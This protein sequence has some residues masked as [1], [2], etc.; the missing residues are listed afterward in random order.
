[1][2]VKVSDWK[3]ETAPLKSVMPKLIFRL[4][5]RTR[6]GQSLLLTGN[7]PLLGE[8]RIENAIPLHYL[9]QDCWE[10][11]VAWKEGA[12]DA[13]IAYEYL[14]RNADGS[15]VRDWGR[16]R[17]IN[18]ARL[19]H[20]EVLVVDSWNEPGWYENAFCTQ[21]FQRVLLKGPADAR[22]A[23]VP[24]AT[25]TFNVKAPLL[26][27]DQTLCL[28]GDAAVLGNWDTTKPPVLLGRVA[29]DGALTVQLYLRGQSFPIAYR[30]AVYDLLKKA[31]VRYEGGEN[32]VLDDVA[33][34]GKHTIVND[35]FAVLPANTWKGAGVAIPVFSLRSEGSF[36]VGEFTDLELLAD[37]GK[38]AGLKLIQLLPINDTTATHTWADSYPYSAISAFALHPLYLNLSHV[39][40]GANR[41]LLE[42]LE[43]EQKRLNAL[44]ALDYEAVIQAKFNFIRR[45]YPS[46]CEK[47]FRS[48]G[49]R[50][51]FKRNRHWLEPYAAFCH[52]RDKHG[53]ADF[54]QWPTHRRYEAE[55]IANL[56]A[57]NSPAY[58]EIAL[59]YF[60][61]YQL[62]L[63]L[64]AAIE[65]AH[66]AGIVVKGDLP[67]GVCR[68]GADTWKDPELYHMEYQAGAPPDPFSAK[69][70]NWSFPTYNWARM[71]AD[72]Y[73]WWW[74]RLEQMN[75]YFD[76]FRIDHILGFFRI[77][78]IPWE[79]VEGLLGHF[80]PAIPV[81]SKEF[82]ARGI[83]IDHDRCAR[84]YI[85]NQILL[86]LFPNDQG[87]VISE[88]LNPG[89]AGNYSLKPEFATQR[90]VEKHFAARDRNERNEK[91]KQGLFDLISNVILF[92]VKGSEGR[93][94]HF[95]FFM[96]H[97]S[98]FK[99]LPA[100]TREQLSDLY[101]DYFSRRQD[102]FWRKEAMEKLPVLKRASNMLVCGEDLGMVPACV[103]DVLKQLGL[104]SLEVQRMPKATNQ[105]FSRPKDAPYLSVVTPSTHDMSTIRGW[106]EEDRTITQTFYNQELGRAGEAPRKCDPWINKAIVQQHL[107]SPAMWSMFQ[108]QDLLGMD[109]ELRRDDVA[110]ERINIPANPKCYWRYRMQPT[111]DTLVRAEGFNGELRGMIQ[112]AGR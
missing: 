66:A 29:E 46:Q 31:F 21:P 96:E 1:M 56:T 87:T 95:R 89:G 91:I 13:L 68:H 34:P 88:F 98:S 24:G 12:P 6:Y 2:A 80:E 93:Q 52:L 82:S 76:A 105:V 54:N 33:R 104:L 85:T 75:C 81:D 106:W 94:Y 109:E 99:S 10:A 15:M 47:V 62:H 18:P 73:N 83:G 40:E 112:Q 36:G 4:R 92:E 7:H 35:G 28:L 42:E 9:N 19:E 39:A 74:R 50:D 45:I 84:P 5:F 16:G 20:E 70:Q 30:Y 22:P 44:E 26:T 102:E 67:I 71:K 53:T 25:H 59:H 17:G 61:Q 101:R 64:T 100:H 60:I 55:K 32:R 69:G 49:Y 41:R 63:Q 27:K 51:F 78:S 97:T 103:P 14:L 37:W 90:Q 72:G 8:G 11:T 43:P 23:A 110:A 58:D 3:S 86:D 108:L 57:E 38:Q 65:H 111:L 107:S 79:G 77:W 48:E